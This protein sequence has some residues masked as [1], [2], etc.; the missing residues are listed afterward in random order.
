L[1]TDNFCGYEMATKDAAEHLGVSDLGTIAPVRIGRYMIL[2][3]GN[4]ATNMSALRDVS[5][6][7]KN[8]ESFALKER[9][10]SQ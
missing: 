2:F 7:V 6:V 3:D 1:G 9:R 8:G 10:C 4:S 5:T